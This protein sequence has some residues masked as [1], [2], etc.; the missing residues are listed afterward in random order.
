MPVSF[1]YKGYDVCQVSRK[2][3]GFTP[4]ATWDIYREGALIKRNFSTR[5]MAKHYI[6]LVQPGGSGSEKG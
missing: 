4:R 6:D 2:I 1:R 5:E 3:A